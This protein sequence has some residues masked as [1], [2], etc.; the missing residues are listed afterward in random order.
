MSLTN[1]II[2]AISI[3]FNQ[4]LMPAGCG[5]VSS[6]S[7]PSSPN[8]KLFDD[9]CI[10]SSLSLSH[11]IPTVAAWPRHRRFTSRSLVL[12]ALNVSRRCTAARYHPSLSCTWDAA[13]KLRHTPIC[14]TYTERCTPLPGV[15]SPL[16]SL[17]HV[18]VG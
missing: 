7:T 10:L 3:H 18:L 16:Y 5:Q 9:R 8:R 11:S 1:T 13:R 15:P 2:H 12:T 4:A 6:I 14:R 17:M